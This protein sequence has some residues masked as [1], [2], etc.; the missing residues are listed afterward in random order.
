MRLKEGLREMASS[1]WTL[2]RGGQPWI[3]ERTVRGGAM[4]R[5]Q[6]RVWTRGVARMM[7]EVMRRG[8]RWAGGAQMPRGRS[9]QA[10][11]GEL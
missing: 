7:E 2:V 11:S 9:G 10:A 8:G 5:A 3:S 1:K 6:L 4:G